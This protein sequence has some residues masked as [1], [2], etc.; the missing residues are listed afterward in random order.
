M[1]QDMADFHIW[2]TYLIIAATVVGY[3]SERWTIEAVALAS[4]AAFLA[5]FTTFPFHAAVGQ[6]ITPELLISGFANPALATVLAL[7][8]V[9]QGLF[10]TDAMDRPARVIAKFGGPSGSGA[11]LVTL[12]AAAV[13]SAILNN[14]PVVV[15]F[16]PILT[17]LAA[18]RNFAV[19][20]ALMPLSFLSILGGMTTLIGSST[21]LLVAGIARDYGIQ[22]D[23]FTMTIPGLALLVAGGIYVLFIMPRFLGRLSEDSGND[24]LQGAGAQFIGDILITANHPFCGQT[25]RGGLFPGLKDL[26]PRLVIRRG[27][28]FFPPFDDLTLSEGDR[29]VITSTKRAMMRALAFGS[30]TV[31]AV[32]DTSP[33]DSEEAGSA[34]GPDYHLA[35]AVIAPG[36]RHAGRTV[37]NAGIET[38]YGLDV[39]GV[40]RK[41]RMGRLPMREI[42]LEPGDTVLVGG[43][44]SA[45]REM[46]NAHDLLLLEWSTEAMPQTRKAWIAFLIFAG[47]VLTAASGMV[48]I[49]ATA[50]IGAFA[51]VATGCLSLQQALRAFDSQIF[52]LVGASIAAAHALEG[53]GGA[54]LIANASVAAMAGQNPAVVLSGMFLVIAILSN[55]LSHTPTAVLFTPIAIGIAEGI[56]A[57]REAFVVAV[58]FAANACFM[59][60][61]GYQTNLLVMGPGRYSFSTFMK[62]GT[63]LVLIIW[64]TFSIVGSWYYGVG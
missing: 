21:N 48:P 40:Q 2:A 41:S 7:L 38:M 27:I 25:A 24:V 16:I 43:T 3:V 28:R 45:L 46:R 44:D 61:I 31:S 36:S 42:R 56:G 15:I 18:Q 13:L 54:A 55:F 62:A 35:E 52:L 34:P 12:S 23:F 58:I 8:I 22:I 10:A 63:P 37:K 60:P 64:L 32:S 14:T 9:G 11:L 26:M 51:M 49:V 29:L 59:T 19:S 53:T 17:V 20:S 50:I 47:V 6:E 30:A 1:G 5:L 4:L 57:P 39:I 33:T